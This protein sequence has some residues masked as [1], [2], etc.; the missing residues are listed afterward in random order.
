[1]GSNECLTASWNEFS[2]GLNEASSFIKMED[3]DFVN[4]STS[5]FVLSLVILIV[6]YD[7]IVGGITGILQIDKLW[8]VTPVIYVFIYAYKSLA[9]RPLLVFVCISIWGMRLSIN[10]C[11]RENYSYFKQPF[12]GHH[13]YRWTNIKQKFGKHTIAWQVF[14]FFF[15]D[16]LQHIIVFSMI[17]PIQILTTKECNDVNPELIERDY[18]F[19]FTFLIT[20]TIEVLVDEQQYQFQT[21]KYRR[22]NHLKE[23]GEDLLDGTIYEIGFP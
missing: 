11:R 8:S 7:F 21:E 22:I 3:L 12:T 16:L 6:I 18:F 20:L 17:L 1:M 13:D 5:G 14:R 9:I 15:A 19:F 23:T 10:F 4:F 2:T